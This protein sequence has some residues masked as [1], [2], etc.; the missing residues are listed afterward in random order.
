[1]FSVLVYVIW[2]LFYVVGISLYFFII[3]CVFLVVLDY[4]QGYFKLYQVTSEYFGK[5]AKSSHL[6]QH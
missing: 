5:S 4:F 1:M 2:K 6:V 3:F